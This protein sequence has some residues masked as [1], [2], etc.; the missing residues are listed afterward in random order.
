MRHYKLSWI[1][2]NRAGIL[3]LWHSALKHTAKGQPP[4]SNELRNA[5]SVVKFDRGIPQIARPWH[6]AANIYAQNVALD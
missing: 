1:A 6:S 5:N 3:D 4:L 2:T